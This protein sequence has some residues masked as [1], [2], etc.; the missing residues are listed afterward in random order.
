MAL[1]GQQH[2]TPHLRAQ[3]PEQD[4]QAVGPQAQG[5][6]EDQLVLDGPG[7]E[8]VQGE[9]DEADV[10]EGG[11]DAEHLQDPH[12]YP[13]PAAGLGHQLRGVRPPHEP[14]ELESVH[15]HLQAEAQQ[16]QDTAAG[17][18]DAEHDH[19]SQGHDDLTPVFDEAVA[20]VGEHLPL[21]F[22]V[23]ELLELVALPRRRSL[24]PPPGTVRDHSH[25]LDDVAECESQEG[26]EDDNH[27]VAEVP[28][29][30][31]R[32]AVV[33]PGH[34]EG[35]VAE[36]SES[37][38]KL[39]DDNLESPRVGVALEVLVVLQIDQLLGVGFPDLLEQLDLPGDHAAGHAVGPVEALA[40]Q[41]G[42]EGI[43]PGHAAHHE[44]N[45]EG[46]EQGGPAP[47]G[48]LPGDLEEVAVH[49][50]GL[51]LAVEPR[52]LLGFHRRKIRAVAPPLVHPPRY[53]G[54]QRDDEDLRPHDRPHRQGY[55]RGVVGGAQQVL[56]NCVVQA[57]LRPHPAGDPQGAEDEDDHGL[58]EVGD[59]V[60]V[61]GDGCPEVGLDLVNRLVPPPHVPYPP[62]GLKIRPEQALPRVQGEIVQQ[63]PQALHGFQ[64]QEVRHPVV[65]QLN[66]V[67]PG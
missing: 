24:L 16:S 10:G 26:S 64:I 18:G 54:L 45:E 12:P 11:E 62:P 33:E 59:E 42:E 6:E 57:V 43:Q 20:G 8:G 50:R 46:G 5:P 9:D 36:G 67:R 15:P 56:A 32:G 7:G 40:V 27:L 66:L 3:A 29:A 23:G 48:G 22:K 53:M 34:G 31:L 17:H 52:I 41:V 35:D 19:V 2:V 55:P 58:D 1:P 38:D 44:R 47:A 13:Q 28:P 14:R 39:E 60:E 37:V 51:E 65:E 61:Q 25:G 63:Q 4:L 21:A 30:P 49:L